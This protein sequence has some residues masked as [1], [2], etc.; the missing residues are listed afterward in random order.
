[1]SHTV[2]L[3][4]LSFLSEFNIFHRSILFFPSCYRWVSWSA[5]VG[6]F[7]GRISKGR[8]I[9]NVVFHSYAIPLGYSIMW[10]GVFGGVGLRQSRQAEGT[11][12][13]V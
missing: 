12:V 3:V 13:C 5:F 10:F 6:L 11:C 2:P 4:F 1:M 8:T 7:I 9:R